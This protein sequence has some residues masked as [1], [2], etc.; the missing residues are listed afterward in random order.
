MKFQDLVF[1]IDDFSKYSYSEKLE[2][3]IL[4]H[5]YFHTNVTIYLNKFC[6]A[7]GILI[8]EINKKDL[9]ISTYWKSALILYKHN[10]NE[11]GWSKSSI[12]NYINIV[13]KILELLL[14]VSDVNL[15]V[16]NNIYL[17]DESFE[18]DH[19]YFFL[20][21]LSSSE[22]KNNFK[23]I[24]GK[25]DNAKSHRNFI[26]LYKSNSTSDDKIENVYVYRPIDNHILKG[27][28][29]EIPHIEYYFKTKK[30]KTNVVQRIF[31]LDESR[32]RINIISKGG[33]GGKPLQL[34]TYEIIDYIKLEL[35]EIDEISEETKKEA[36]LAS[37]KEV[38]SPL[39]DSKS[40][41]LVSRDFSTIVKNNSIEAN[42]KRFLINKA[43]SNTYIYK[44]INL[45]T[46]YNKPSLPIFKGFINYLLNSY[47]NNFFIDLIILSAILGIPIEKLIYSIL[48]LDDMFIYKKI[49]KHYSKLN[50]KINKN[51]FAEYFDA[52]DNQLSHKVQKEGEIYIIKSLE[53]KW[54]NLRTY[55]EKYIISSMTYEDILSFIK[56]HSD[57]DI[58]LSANSVSIYVKK[59]KELQDFDEIKKYVKKNFNNR[60]VGDL[61]KLK[62]V[63]YYISD[64]IKDNMSIYAKLVK[65][66][67]KNI[68]INLKNIHTLFY[69]YFKVYNSISDIQL[70]FTQS[71]SKN[72][73][74]RLT[75]C[76]STK[77]LITYEKWI[78]NMIIY[79]DLDS[80]FNNEAS[81]YILSDLDYSY[82][83]GS[84]N[85]IKAYKFKEFLLNLNKLN[86]N[87]EIVKINILMIY[88]R[89]AFSILLVSRDFIKTSSNLSQVSK[90]FKII[91][92]QE[93]G[94][95]VYQGKRILP[96]T[97]KAIEY[98]DMFQKIKKQYGISDSSPV[99][100]IK[101]DNELFEEAI[102]KSNVKKYFESLLEIEKEPFKYHEN[103]VILDNIMRFTSYVSI[104][105]GRHVVT[106]K[107]VQQ[108][109]PSEYID[110]I[111]NHHQLGKE[112]QGKYSNFN[113]FKYIKKTRAVLKNI[114]E[115]YF[116]SGLKAKDFL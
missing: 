42:Y 80:Y 28:S 35:T 110:A 2:S 7:Y 78:Y 86:I 108:G 69:H 101:K 109:I 36:S 102:T 26:C 39:L 3:F 66:F 33:L 15:E 51:Y 55:L 40:A 70:L 64:L 95:N 90:K 105:F 5:G 38:V 22:I 107:M 41:R 98:I 31:S 32:G 96:L 24:D 18:F 10:I 116:P 52:S 83:I 85:Y 92:I 43:I 113:T 57:Q 67:S 111:M 9:I 104:N 25:Y 77:R 103:K 34:K 49:K 93:K 73:E 87:D 6:Q 27:P 75:Y 59:C 76:N 14:Y 100:I 23:I 106:T 58:G 47:K 62:I 115:E 30:H 79:L 74:A 1:S 29:K 99:L 48:D 13:R 21:K 89:Y 72:D 56:E 61:S 88:L 54:L 44:N 50:V 20:E 71:I 81:E 91:T 63:D 12:E 8:E 37:S 16:L 53:K 65:S 19:Y 17:D 11:T 60:D 84:N 112:D 68:K 4:N 82:R 114:E 94:K 45:E 97:D 46:I